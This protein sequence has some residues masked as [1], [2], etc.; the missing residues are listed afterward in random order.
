MKKLL[1]LVTLLAMLLSLTGCG[2]AKQD[3]YCGVYEARS[4]QM[5]GII[6]SVKKVYENGFS[7]ELKK[8]GKA[9][10]HIDDADYNIKWELD[11]TRV[12]LIAA[13]T[14]FFG[15][16][17]DGVMTLPDFLSSGVDFTLV[18]NALVPKDSYSAYW[19]GKWYGWRIIYS[20]WGEYAASE[21][22]A[23]DVIAEISVTGDTGAITVWDFED[24]ESDPVAV[25]KVRFTEGATEYGKMVLTEG[26]AFGVELQE[27]AWEIDPGVSTVKSLDHMIEIA[28]IFIDEENEENGFEYHMFLRPWGMDWEDVITAESDDFLYGDMMPVNY[29]DWYLPQIGIVKPAAEYD[30]SDE[31]E[32]YI[33]LEDFDLEGFDPEDFDLTEVFPEETEEQP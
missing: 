29:D 26:E 32:E 14:E 9:V 10:L 8:G 28:G 1:C 33:D 4:G 31:S 30:D 5:N 20:G 13:D 23:W 17:E 27:G 21:D 15:T 18:C 22:T 12:H 25:G 11:G 24:E 7:I 3:A 16:L 6:V 2:S 19:D